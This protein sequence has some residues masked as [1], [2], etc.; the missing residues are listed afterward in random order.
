MRRAAGSGRRTPRLW[1][2]RRVL[3][4]RYWALHREARGL[5][6]PLPG[7]GRSIDL[8]LAHALAGALKSVRARPGLAA[9]VVVT[10]ALSI[11]ITTVVFSVVNGVLLRP[12]P[13]AAPERIV[14]VY[15]THGEWLESPSPQLRAFAAR[16]PLSYPIFEG[17][18]DR[19]TVFDG[20][21]AYANGQFTYTPEGEPEIV[22]G[23][24]VTAG[25]LPTLG[26]QPEL[27]RL[28]L[29]AEDEMGSPPVVVVSHGFWQRRLGGDPDV[30]GRVI[31]FD[32]RPYEIVGVMP[33]SFYFPS[34]G[35]AVWVTFD[36][37]LRSRGLGTQFMGAVARVSPGVDPGAVVRELEGLQAGVHDDLGEPLP[38]GRGARV[39]SRLAE[40]VGDVRQTLLV[41]LGS[42]GLV[43]AIACGNV[44]N[45]LFVSGLRRRRELAV[46]AALGAGTPRLVTGLFAETAVLVGVGGALGL[47]LALVSHGPVVDLLPMGI[48][49]TGEIA[50]NGTVLSFSAAV[51][52]VTA[53]LAGSLPAVLAARTDPA[54]GLKEGLRDLGGSRG[55][56]RVRG[57]LVVAE[58]AL[59]F[60][61]L[62]GA[63]LLANSF[64]RLTRVDVGFRPE[65]VAS[66]QV[67]IPS[68]R[69]PDQE[70][71]TAF[72]DD[73][74]RRLEATPGVVGVAMTTET[75]FAGS[76]SS[77]SAWVER[78]DS[79]LE[80]LNVELASVS[81]EYFRLLGI[82]L[83]AGRSFQAADLRGGEPVAV[84]SE[85][86]A[87]VLWPGESPVGKRV[88]RGSDPANPRWLAVVGVVADVHHT[89]A[90]QPPVPKLYTPL[91]LTWQ[92]HADFL[93]AAAG[94]PSS[95]LAQ[96]RRAVWDTDP[97][98]P[99]R[100]AM[101]VSDAVDRSMAQPR[102]RALL[103]GSLA[104]LSGL[105][106]VLG[107]TGTV[108]FAVSQR[109]PEI[110]VRLALGA[111]PAAVV[112]RTTRGG[113]A[114]AALG[115]GIGLVVALPAAR[116]L[117]E[118]LFGI[119][120]R[121]PVTFVATLGLV[122]FAGAAASWLPAR[123]AAR[124]D[125][126]RVLNAE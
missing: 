86:A 84:L 19:N 7:G 117:E 123:R 36:D 44:A 65:H 115:I 81:E 58:V 32:D 85:G 93:V 108:A 59:A 37:E 77:G 105:L 8:S 38:E 30:V 49:R 124:I 82:P 71:K 109:V 88:G 114:L 72:A 12:L 18:R 48:P 90:A 5:A 79:E 110:G 57:A 119:G 35:N 17:W 26:V 104:A 29:P 76:V 24:H 33:P 2:W 80:E 15:Q 14:N 67:A 75:P 16:F 11:G 70:S 1:Y 120:A 13:Y 99:I 64:W 61:L 103:I 4:L 41:L 74:R 23:I 27:G 66:L 20:F 69:Y 107:V 34:A 56:G 83:Q 118:M 42:V 46:R 94:D 51:T 111:S 73:I 100:H 53:L 54:N 126:V 55:T 96:A 68:A 112:A 50:L 40:V 63:G 101:V 125:P 25:V 122:L 92:E 106:A 28:P 91:A 62:T 39:E 45:L 21:G 31:R 3:T 60:V 22:H 102:F 6:A 116:A 78:A 10:L 89:S 9:V 87:Q 47:L 95:V 98:V 52:V 43:L 113:V 97:R 121:D